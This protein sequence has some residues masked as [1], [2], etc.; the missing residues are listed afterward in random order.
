MVEAFT[1]WHV[2]VSAEAVAA[3]LFARS[4]YDVSVQYGARG[5]VTQ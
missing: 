3:S 2:G 1:G 5:K 4:G